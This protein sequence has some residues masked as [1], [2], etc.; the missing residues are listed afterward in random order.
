MEFKSFSPILAAASVALVLSGGIALATTLHSST[1]EATAA[2]PARV[3]SSMSELAVA[4][5][6]TLGQTI[7]KWSDGSSRAQLYDGDARGLS[8]SELDQARAAAVYY[9][10]SDG[11]HTWEYVTGVA[12]DRPTEPM[13]CPSLGSNGPLFECEES[14]SVADGT[15]TRTTSTLSIRVGGT[16]KDPLFT[17]TENVQEQVREHPEDARLIREVRSFREG[18][19]VK[20]AEFVY[21][22]ESLELADAF[23]L[24]AAAMQ[25]IVSA[26]ELNLRLPTSLSAD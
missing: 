13:G 9:R 23:L 8:S 7:V 22:S 14:G 25:D 19:Y 21:G 3:V 26:D 15:Y 17:T 16:D 2:T 20:V 6:S 12:V 24:N 18:S 5:E 10:T 11:S 4:A 1:S